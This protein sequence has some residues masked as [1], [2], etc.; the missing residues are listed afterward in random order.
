MWGMY[1][2]LFRNQVDDTGTKHETLM[3][4][5][6]VQ[7]PHLQQPTF[8]PPHQPAIVKLLWLNS[9]SITLR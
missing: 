8:F 7:L 9:V 4:S 2:C 6:L 5:V 1:I 3:A